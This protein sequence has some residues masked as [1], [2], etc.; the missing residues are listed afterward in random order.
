MHKA[1]PADGRSIIGAV[2]AKTQIGVEEYLDLVCPD[3]PEPDYGHG[4]VVERT[5]PTPIHAQ[6]QALLGLLFAPLL[7]GRSSF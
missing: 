7:V 2:L 1:R 5:F 4:E 3:R 6:L